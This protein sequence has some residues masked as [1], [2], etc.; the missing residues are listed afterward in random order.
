MYQILFFVA[1]FVLLGN[2]AELMAKRYEE[3]RD[4]HVPA[5]A[6]LFEAMGLGLLDALANAFKGWRFAVIYW[7][8]KAQD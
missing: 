7:I 8:D 6:A 1:L 5:T 3:L 2:T 4:N